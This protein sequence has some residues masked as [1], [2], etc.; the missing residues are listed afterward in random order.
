MDSNFLIEVHFGR[1]NISFGAETVPVKYCPHVP[2]KSKSAFLLST[3]II[4]SSKMD[5]LSMVSFPQVYV[6]MLHH[7]NFTPRIMS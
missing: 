3:L 7:L 1:Q 5:R 4:Q 6:Y 2:S